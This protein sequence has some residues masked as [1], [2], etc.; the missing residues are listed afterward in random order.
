MQEKESLLLE[1]WAGSH[2][3][4][5]SRL[6]IIQHTADSGFCEQNKPKTPRQGQ[7]GEV[8]PYCTCS[9]EGLP[10]GWTVSCRRSNSG[11]LFFFTVGVVH[12][13]I[14]KDKIG[15]LGSSAWVSGWWSSLTGNW[16]WS[17]LSQDVSQ[18]PQRD[19][20]PHVNICVWNPGWGMLA[21]KS[22]VTIKTDLQRSREWG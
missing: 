5:A 17:A 3:W 1:E 14:M 10:W 13:N 19:L 7:T 11:L 22:L 6:G 21:C 8:M 20:Q 18:T 2:I 4:P 15:R 12:I 9:S 16:V